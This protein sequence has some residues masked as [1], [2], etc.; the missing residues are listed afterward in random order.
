MKS[1]TFDAPEY[2][3]DGRFVVTRYQYSGSEQSGWQ[4]LREH[5]PWLMLGPGYRLLPVHYCGIC[6]TDLARH[7]LP[8]AL[9]QITGHEI[10]VEA[11]GQMAVVE[12]NASHLALGQDGSGCPCCAQ[13]WSSHC[14]QRLTLGIDR[15]PGGFAPYILAPQRAIHLLPAAIDPVV[16]T[17]IE[18]LA[19]ALRA[20]HFTP[21]HEGDQIAVLGPR[22]L[23]MLLLAAL[24]D[25]RQRHDLD[26]SITALL[27]RPQLASMC[28]AFGADQVRFVAQ[29]DGDDAAGQYDIVFDTTGSP[30]GLITAL[31]YARRI[32]HVK[33]T[34][35]LPVSGMSKLD[36]LVVNELALLPP[37]D[38]ADD[39]RWPLTL[40]GTRAVRSRSIEVATLDQADH[41]LAGPLRC[42]GM[43]LHPGG[44]LIYS[45]QERQELAAAIKQRGIA[46]HSS[47]CGEF[48]PAIH[49]LARHC[50]LHQL[51]AEEW[52]SQIPIGQIHDAFVRARGDNAAIKLVMRHGDGA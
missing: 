52:I 35:G 8:F 28:V 29:R 39:P 45:G 36:Q 47:R 31:Q 33:S 1:V 13:G 46:L 42:D 40:R 22:R 38:A 51:L 25:Y 43:A 16:A 14:P 50:H 32:V 23:G 26:F 27:R 20:L 10:V 3:Q 17:A 24:S 11:D 6:A 34:H 37:L 4:I 30:Q 44:A 49:L 15:L 21:P 5:Q 7:R 41:W 19:A 2:Q 18:P 12:I 48:A 9:P